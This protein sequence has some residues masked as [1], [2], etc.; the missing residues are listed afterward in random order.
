LSPLLIPQNVHCFLFTS[1]CSCSFSSSSPSM[2]CV[3]W[4]HSH[5]TYPITVSLV[6]FL[7][8][9]RVFNSSLPGL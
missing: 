7:H 6:F 4:I 5:F 2:N 9:N 3:T 1:R 8:K